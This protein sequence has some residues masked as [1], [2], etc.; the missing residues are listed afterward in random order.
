MFYS[1][2]RSEG[3]AGGEEATGGDLL[4]HINAVTLA[5]N[6]MWKLQTN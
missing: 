3:N 6:V 5:A 1:D 4:V 2:G